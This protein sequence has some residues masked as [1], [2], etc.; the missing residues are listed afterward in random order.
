M[1]KILLTD[2]K[3]LKKKI[4][5]NWYHCLPFF[6][7]GPLNSRRRRFLCRSSG[8]FRRIKYKW[9]RLRGKEVIPTFEIAS[10]PSIKLSDIKGRRHFLNKEI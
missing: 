10:C 9:Y 3:D 5:G 2:K 7:K 6:L 4:S 8:I 1:R